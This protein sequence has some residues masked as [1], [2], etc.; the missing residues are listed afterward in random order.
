MNSSTGSNNLDDYYSDAETTE[1]Q[2]KN[3][4][5]EAA[6]QL[7]SL[8]KE[9]LR[10]CDDSYNQGKEDAYEE[11]LK[12]FLTYANGSGGNFK[13]VSVNEFFN[14]ISLKLQDQRSGRGSKQKMTSTLF[15]SSIS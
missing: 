10:K 11:V 5:Q 15:N 7:M 2:R 13:H 1:I 8:Y 12:W 4:F 9:S 14:F 3:L 6:S